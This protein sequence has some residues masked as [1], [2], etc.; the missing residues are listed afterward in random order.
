[1]RLVAPDEPA[2]HSD[3]RTR[4]S[5]SL[6]RS[7]AISRS[8]CVTAISRPSDQDAPNSRTPSSSK[9]NR[10]NP[11]PSPI[12][13]TAP[14]SSKRKADSPKDPV[15]VSEPTG[16]AAHAS[17]P[18]ASPQCQTANGPKTHNPQTKIRRP[19][20]R[21]ARRSTNGPQTTPPQTPEGPGL[22]APFRRA[23]IV[24]VRR[25]PGPINIGTAS[26]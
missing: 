15:P 16:P 19:K 22:Y 12:P 10:Q 23:S 25:W 11:P 5:R 8:R 4:P 20:G 26:Q 24:D 9:P 17:L 7:L 13:G 21:R 6:S 1:M 14:F 18:L 2:N 3:R